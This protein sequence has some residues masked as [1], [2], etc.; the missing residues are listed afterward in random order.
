M[1]LYKIDVLH[2]LKEVGY[3][4]Y[5]LQKEKLFSAG[6]V[7]KLRKGDVSI[8]VDTL[9]TLCTLLQ[10]QPGDILDTEINFV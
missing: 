9:N 7:D 3:S 4:S 1:I 5:R 8:T 6:V 2:E 10:C